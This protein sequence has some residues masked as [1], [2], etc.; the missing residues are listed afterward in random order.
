VRALSKLGVS[1]RA[2]CRLVDCP[3]A[4]IQDVSRREP[5]DPAVIDSM[6]K[7]ASQRLR[8]GRR[9]VHFLMGREGFDISE[10]R[11]RRMYRAQ[12]LQIRARKK[13]HVQY[14][15]GTTRLVAT[16]PNQC[17]WLDFL[18]EILLTRRKFRVLDI[19]DDFT[20]I[21]LQLDIDFSFPSPQVTRILD[22][23]AQACGGYPDVLR[24]DQGPE[25]TALAMLQWAA[26]HNVRLQFS[27]QGKPTQNAHIESLNGRVRD[28]FLNLF[29]F[30]KP[31][32]SSKRCQRLARRPQPRSPARRAQRHDADRVPRS[33]QRPP[34]VLSGL[35]SDPTLEPRAKRDDAVPVNV[36]GLVKRVRSRAAQI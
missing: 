3:R 24:V 21:N 1:E 31:V 30:S 10:R 23:I 28:E 33:I 35:N 9:R 6:R 5:N 19:I 16:K 8:F 32:R 4:T 12:I 36:N 15:R 18:H 7:I 25:L 20:R 13:R 22:E 14:V 17:W 29:F 11:F 26:E 34:T 2:A 27:D